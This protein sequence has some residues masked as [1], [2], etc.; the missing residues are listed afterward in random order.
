[1]HHHSRRIA[2]L[3]L[4][5]LVAVVNGSRYIHSRVITSGKFRFTYYAKKLKDRY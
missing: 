4:P 1:M 5:L 3:V 2:V